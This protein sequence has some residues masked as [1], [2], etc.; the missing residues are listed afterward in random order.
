MKSMKI[1]KDYRHSYSPFMSFMLFMVKN[2]LYCFAYRCTFQRVCRLR[3][4]SSA[5]TA[6]PQALSRKATPSFD[7]IVS[8]K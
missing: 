2:L 6:K 3:S 1:R 5:G 7:P 4:T 8:R